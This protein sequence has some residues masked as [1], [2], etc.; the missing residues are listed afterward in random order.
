MLNAI[1]PLLVNIRRLFRKPM[2]VNFPIE[3]RYIPPRYRGG[4]FGL[5][6]NE[7]GEDNCIACQLCQRICPSQI[8]TVVRGM[9][10]V[11]T[12]DG[13]KK[14]VT[15]PEE[16]ILDL[17]ACMKCELCVQ[18]CPVDA[19]VM[20]PSIGDTA[21]SREELVLDINKLHE[22]WNKFKMSVWATGESLRAEQD[23]KRTKWMDVSDK[24]LIETTGKH[25]E[26]LME[27]KVKKV[28]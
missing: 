17:N 24:A 2:T 15:Y 5:S 27:G 21:L 1:K 20:L 28:V 19:I 11:E 14:K 25:P 18:V 4:T 3:R 16:F 26:K 8:I 10:E 12:E 6:L 7:D 22:N 9:K 13:K 23:P